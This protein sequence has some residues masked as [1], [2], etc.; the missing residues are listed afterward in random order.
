VVH[1]FFCQLDTIT[2]NYISS[3]IATSNSQIDWETIQ[4]FLILCEAQRDWL[5]S[6]AVLGLQKI[7]NLV[8][9][10]DLAVSIKDKS[11][12]GRG[13]FPYRVQ[14]FAKERNVAIHPSVVLS[15]PRCELDAI[16]RDDEKHKKGYYKKLSK[17]W[18]WSFVVC[19][20]TKKYWEF[21]RGRLVKIQDICCGPRVTYDTSTFP[22]LDADFRYGYRR[23]I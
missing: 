20:D 17:Q 2:Q 15:S 7:D 12:I 8:Y 9:Y 23:V 3:T 5:N 19:D 13:T 11:Y 16:W 14:Q 22:V 21:E 1:Q 10:L 18:G 4:D 6:Q